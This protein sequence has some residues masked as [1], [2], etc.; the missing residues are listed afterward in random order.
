MRRVREPRTGEGAA[1]GYYPFTGRCK[2]D[3]A[4][5]T[6]EGRQITKPLGGTP[7]P[8]TPPRAPFFQLRRGCSGMAKG[9][10]VEV[11][12]DMD[13]RKLSFAVNGAAPVDSG[14]LLPTTGVR[15][16]MRLFG[17]GDAIAMTNVKG[18]S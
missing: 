5:D 8:P 11:L 2:V 3:D 13:A 7:M 9:C 18:P 17:K 12:V 6:S 16:W 14:V 4:K 10:K 15:P 1:W